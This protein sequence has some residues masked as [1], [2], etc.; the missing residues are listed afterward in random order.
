MKRLALLAFRFS[1]FLLA[2]G[3]WLLSSASAQQINIGLSVQYNHVYDPAKPMMT[4]QQGPTSTGDLTRW[5]S[6][7]GALMC[8]ISNDG[9]MSG[10][11]CPGG[12]SG[13]V[14]NFSAGDL[15]PLFTTSV[16]NPHT[17]PALSFTQSN[18]AANTVFGNFT[19]VPAPPSFGAISS[20]PISLRWDQISD[21]VVMTGYDKQAEMQGYF[22]DFDNIP[23]LGLASST[24]SICIGGLNS[25]GAAASCLGV[26]AIG[27]GPGAI[28]AGLGSI[29]IGD[30]ASVAADASISIGTSGS[31]TATGISGTSFT[32]VGLDD[33][34]FGVTYS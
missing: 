15:S 7:A 17:S 25:A 2:S 26:S 4:F 18:A 32:G 34:V 27:L 24:G 13:S 3:L 19:G 12:G 6:R 1:L 33:A 16:A 31:V 14:T 30:L 20:L 8:S 22:L 5:F 21:E 29:T 9:V 28:S 11:G 10:P 23:A